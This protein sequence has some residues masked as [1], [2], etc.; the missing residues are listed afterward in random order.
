[1]EIPDRLFET[2]LLA[3][4]DAAEEVKNG[5]LT[6]T[7]IPEVYKNAC[8]K[9]ACFS[10]LSK[11]NQPEQILEA[12]EKARTGEWFRSKE[13]LKVIRHFYLVDSIEHKNS[14]TEKSILFVLWCFLGG[15]YSYTK[16]TVP[17]LMRTGAQLYLSASKSGRYSY[18][19]K[20]RGLEEDEKLLVQAVQILKRHSVQVFVQKGTTVINDEDEKKIQLELERKIEAYGGLK[21]LQELF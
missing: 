4:R 8:K 6:V 11:D 7:D 13:L 2:I 12:R 5:N 17:D 21:F 20:L 9:L 1:M 19:C 14:V 15:Q 3:V 16:E 18:M 10:E